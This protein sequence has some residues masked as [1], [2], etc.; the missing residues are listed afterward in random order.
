ML[1]KTLNFAQNFQILSDT[2][3]FA[4]KHPNFEIFKNKAIRHILTA[5]RHMWRVA[6]GLDNAVLEDMM[7]LYF[8]L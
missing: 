4:Q 3:N 5:I 8:M 2:S 1:I 6:N 7:C